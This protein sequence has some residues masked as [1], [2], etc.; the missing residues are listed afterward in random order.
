[1]PKSDRSA[2]I[3][4][5]ALP[6]RI[7][8]KGLEIMLITSRETK[9]WV[10]PKG[11]PMPGKTPHRVAEIEA[12]QEAGVK[13]VVSKK[14]TGTYF[15]QKALPRGVQRLCLVEVYALR[16]TREAPIWREKTQRTRAWFS[17]EAATY[18]VEEGGLAEIIAAW[19]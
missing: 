15:Y 7:G 14:P 1:M 6:Y 12:F 10:I 4:F 8:P 2:S 18:C 19:V 9:R 3:Q 16:V 17:A 5:G 11:W 13:G